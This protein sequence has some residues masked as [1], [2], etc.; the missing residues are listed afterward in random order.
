MIFINDGSGSYTILGHATWNG[1]LLG[2]LVFPCFI[3]IM[4]VCVPIASSVQLK[5]GHSKLQICYSILKVIVKKKDN[6]STLPF[7]GIILECLKFSH[8]SRKS[9]KKV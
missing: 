4:G 3:W 6:G 5:R 8:I 7:K 2:D 1:I 9:V